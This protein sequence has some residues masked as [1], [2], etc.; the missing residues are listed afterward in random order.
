[1][2]SLLTPSRTDPS[3]EPP[4]D[5]TRRRRVRLAAL[6]GA[7]AALAVGTGLLL[8][9]AVVVLARIGGGAPAPE[10]AASLRT[11]GAIWLATQHV[12]VDLPSGRLALVPWGL[13]ALPA[14]LLWRAGRALARRGSVAGR[15]QVGEA[16]GALAGTYALLA[17]FVGLAAA[18]P[19]GRPDRL[20]A[21][22]APGGLALLVGGAAVAREA[23]FLPGV[24]RRVPEVVRS[25]LPAAAA[26]LAVLVAGGALLAGGALAAHLPRAARISSALH[27]D[28]LDGAILLLVGLAYVPTA[29][30]WAMAYATGPG[31]AL[32][33]ATAVA[34]TGIVLGPVPAI[35]L[36]AALPA[37]G[38][39]PVPSLAAL[40]TPLAAG[41]VSG[42]LV[43][44]GRAWAAG[45]RAALVGLV[46]G[47]ATGGAVGL[48]ALLAAGSLAGG[49]L[50]TVGPSA[51]QVA[52]ATTAEVAPITAV[53][54][55]VAAAGQRRRA[56]RGGPGVSWRSGLRGSG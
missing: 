43:A 4:A 29:I 12:P 23:G 37:S 53:V 21:L 14:W 56:A 35:P 38:P 25:A 5:H 40:V 13:T 45:W 22:L 50:V 39:A 2:A 20:A 1:M 54:A 28:A 47:T 7:L 19:G 15:R 34:P 41:V 52:A 16:V 55:W 48:L 30:V 10:V 8:L 17:G 27:A 32:G 11:A 49:R 42:L 46:A 3:A 26:G 6:A 31:F 51:W 24:V 18:A 44:R 33:T 36:L 9:G